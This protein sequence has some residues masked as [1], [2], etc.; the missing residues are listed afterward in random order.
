MGTSTLAARAFVALVLAA[1]GATKLLDPGS[2]RKT[3]LEFGVGE[4]LSRLSAALPA[5]ELVVALGLMIEPTAR[6]AAIAAAV[7]VLLFM[8]GIANAIRLGRRPDCG[9]FGALNS[10]P[11]GARTLIRNG[12]LL[13]LC[14][15]VMS[16]GP[17]PSV[18]RWLDM[19]SGA[20]IVLVTGAD[21]LV[22]SAWFGASRLWP[23]R[24]ALPADASA[25][26]SQPRIVPG[27]AAPDF[28]AADTEGNAYTLG[29][30]VQPDRALVLIFG[31][32]GCGTCITLFEQL[33]DWKQALEPSLQ[34]AVISPGD[35]VWA[36][37]LKERYQLSPILLDPSSDI[38][39]SFAV[40]ITPTAYVVTEDRRIANGPAVGPDA[41]EDLIRL[42]LQRIGPKAGPWQPMI[43][44]A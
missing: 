13:V 3:F 26:R 17:G 43:Q 18:T 39:R 20:A 10:E 32:S 41:I 37:P 44:P 7:L 25:S 23:A 9:C 2:L 1:A 27:D 11:I 5:A 40:R 19:H 4:L 21:L 38:A 33:A 14:V 24:Q 34:L 6:W 16:L 42:T 8:L 12:I 28:E 31:S 35:P 15:S 29:T 36:S 30:L 22:L